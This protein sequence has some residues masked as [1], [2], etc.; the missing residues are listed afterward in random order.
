M[1]TLENFE[2]LC[3]RPFYETSRGG[4][5]SP[6]KTQKGLSNEILEKATQLEVL[7]ISEPK[8]INKLSNAMKA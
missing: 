7:M 4:N 1:C 5:H 8:K 2:E 3:L 6:N